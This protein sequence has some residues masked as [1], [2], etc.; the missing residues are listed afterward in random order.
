MYG[1]HWCV[2]V[3]VY[4]CVGFDVA[5][6]WVKGFECPAVENDSKRELAV[7]SLRENELAV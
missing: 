2:H 1:T 6:R 7:N 4:V 3:C 5:G